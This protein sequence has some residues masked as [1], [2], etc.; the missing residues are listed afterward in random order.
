MG[1]APQGHQEAAQAGRYDGGQV[2]QAN[3]DGRRGRNGA[4]MSAGS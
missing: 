2:K 3:E 4:G 1:D